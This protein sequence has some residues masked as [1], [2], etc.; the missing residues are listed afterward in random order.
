MLVSPNP[1]AGRVKA[2]AKDVVLVLDRSGS[3]GGEK[4][5]Q[6]RDA[7]RYILKNLNAEDRFNV[8]A[9]HDGVDPF[10]DTLVDYSDKRLEDALDRVDRI[11]AGGGTALHKALTTAMEMCKKGE[12]PT[13]VIFLTDGLP[14]IGTTDEGEIIKDTTKAND[15]NA[16]LFAFG[17]GYNV[18][19][20]LL[21]NLVRKNNG[22]SDY[23]K[24]K[25]DVEAKVSSLYRK[26]RN[27]VMTNVAVKVT[28]LDLRDMYPRE[29]GDLFEGDQLVL[30][31]RYDALG[32]GEKLDAQVVVTGKYMG[33]E[34]GFEYPVTIEP[35][36]KDDRH[37]YVERLW[38][39]RRIGYLLDQVQLAGETQEV[40]DEIIKL[41]K[42]YGI[43]TPYTS[44]LARED[45]KLG[46][47]NGEVREEFE[48][49]AGRLQ[50]E[51]RGQGGQV[52]AKN[53]Q[54]LNESTRAAEPAA[55][56]APASGPG[57][58]GI[59]ADSAS[60][61]G[62]SSGESYEKDKTERVA[63]VRQVG[64][65]TLYKR[66]KGWIT[67][68]AAARIEKDKAEVQEIE[69]FSDE[70]F[71]LVNKNTV[72]QNRVLASQRA[73]EELVVELRGQVYR[74]R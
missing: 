62:Y 35:G 23:V 18:N 8:I 24:P 19:V 29:I 49:R 38:A 54:A 63:N 64:N 57:S 53:R 32:K 17:V 55:A 12:R 65:Q 42:E 14:T 56:P 27:P 40:T 60:V 15:C 69:R 51:I 30:V 47:D 28:D 50:S 67:P 72:E 39:M 45:V 2:V 4:I 36:D 59:A 16:R 33:K 48:Q 5:E 11:E 58:M 73:D 34:R 68:Q 71:A 44:F 25:E 13:Y 9:Y 70:Y 26:I 61:V 66:D 20:R 74:I 22:R 21:D 31:G 7:A 6:A 37:A 41:S 43:M 52:A 1:S 46:V 10:Y 3:M